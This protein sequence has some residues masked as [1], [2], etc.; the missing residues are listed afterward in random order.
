MSSAVPIEDTTDTQ[1]RVTI[2]TNSE[3]STPSDRHW[4]LCP[5][6]SSKR[7][8]LILRVLVTVI[9]LGFF[10]SL[11][12]LTLVLQSQQQQHSNGTASSSGVDRG[13]G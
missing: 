6:F 3:H 12:A 7:G 5:Q 10:S 9:C 13:N 4:S 2:N 1:I 11:E 8:T